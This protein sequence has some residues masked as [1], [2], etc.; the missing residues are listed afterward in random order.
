MSGIQG[1]DNPDGL[2]K[3]VAAVPAGH[4]EA[5]QSNVRRCQLLAKASMKH[6]WSAVL[7]MAM[8]GVAQAQ[9]I[10]I[11]AF[12]GSNTYGKNLS[13]SAA[14][15]AQLEAM[16]KAKGHDVVVLNEGTNGQTTSEELSKID[17]AIPADTR[18]VI[19]QPGGNDRRVGGQDT[20][21]NI[22]AIVRTLLDRKILVLFCG[23]E[24]KRAWVQKFDVPTID[25]I[26]KLAPG[27][28]QLDGQH[29]TEKGYRLAAEKML[30]AVEGLIELAKTK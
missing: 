19:F 27:E 8:M 4:Q 16:L 30:P 24:G 3:N 9:P 25:E 22:Q 6:T 13:R 23:G 18:I 28:L 1:C 14:Y 21:S 5:L 10:K 15:P 20:K 11:V 26:N 29:L 7:L 12:G 2:H 17:S